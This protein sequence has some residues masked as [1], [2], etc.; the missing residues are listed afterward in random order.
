VWRAASWESGESNERSGVCARGSF[1]APSRFSAP[2]SCVGRGG[3]FAFF[4]PL[5]VPAL[6]L[7]RAWALTSEGVYI[8]AGR[9]LPGRSLALGASFGRLVSGLSQERRLL[10]WPKSEKRLTTKV[11]RNT[12]ERWAPRDLRLWRDAPR[13][14]TTKTQDLPDR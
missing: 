3:A 9:A 12:W 6:P 5:V 7:G 8:N 14:M 1:D 4:F 2:G 11:P 10:R 13:Q